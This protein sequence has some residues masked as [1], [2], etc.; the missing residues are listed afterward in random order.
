MSLRNI[1]YKTIPEANSIN[2]SL[3]GGTLFFRDNW[4]GREEVVGLE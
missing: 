1:N 3:E 4:G 2:Q